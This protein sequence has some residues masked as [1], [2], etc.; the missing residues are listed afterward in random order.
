MNINKTK[1]I[2]FL[3]FK[4]NLYQNSKFYIYAEF[5]RNLLNDFTHSEIETFKF[6]FN[7]N[8][9]ASK[10]TFYY[11]DCLDINNKINELKIF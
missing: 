3:N 10:G 8:F 9:E 6:N 1:F 4:I 11:I 5:Y 2:N 7:A